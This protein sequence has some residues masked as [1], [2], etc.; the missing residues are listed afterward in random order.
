[1]KKMLLIAMLLVAP[2]FAVAADLGMYN[3]WTDTPESY[4]LT[5]AEKAEWQALTSAADAEKFV[6][7][8]RAKRGGD[9][10]T[11]EVTKRA[12]MADKYLTMGKVKGSAST[13]GKFVI[14]FGPPAGM[15]VAE[16]KRNRNYAGGASE[17]G[18]GGELGVGASI[19]TEMGTSQAVGSDASN[20]ANLKDYTF[21]FAGKSNP[22]LAGQDLVV[23]VEVN[24]ASG[25]DKIRDKKAVKD[26]DEKIE[27]AAQAS[28]K[29][30]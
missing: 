1:M 13:R 27:A 8:F 20:P 19:G 30:R 18:G 2:V 11:K 22:A 3:Q 21:T 4:F 23:V 15:E 25:K 29:T 14:L 7:A 28:I 17:M 26:L 24:T 5:K 10:F 12:E 16:K 6:A 9:A